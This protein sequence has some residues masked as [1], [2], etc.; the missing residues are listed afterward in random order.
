MRK[1]M[2][3]SAIGLT[4]ALSGAALASG[5]GDS[6]RNH[7][8]RSAKAHSD[9]RGEHAL[10]RHSSRRERGEA[11]RDHDGDR[12]QDRNRDRSRT[13]KSDRRSLN[14]RSARSISLLPHA[15]GMAGR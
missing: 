8:E 1:T 4:L 13:H 11:N 6:K 10:S 12:D 5:D 3:L 7:Q 14:A 15:S 2:L 9:D